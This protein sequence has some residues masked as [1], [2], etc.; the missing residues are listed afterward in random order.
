MKSSDLAPAALQKL[1]ELKNLLMSSETLDKSFQNSIE[2]HADMLAVALYLN[3][4]AYEL[5]PEKKHSQKKFFRNPAK[6][7]S[8]MLKDSQ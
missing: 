5:P 3:V 7:L 2:F 8:E 6:Y 4:S 1:T